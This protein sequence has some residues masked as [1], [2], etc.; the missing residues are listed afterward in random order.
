MLVTNAGIYVPGS[1]ARE[2]RL[3]GEPGE[4][5]SD[6]A[7]LFDVL[8]A[9]HGVDRY[10]T[11]ALG[12]VKLQEEVGEACRAFLRGNDADLAKELGDVVL[13]VQGVARHLGIDVMTAVRLN[14]ENSV[15]RIVDPSPFVAPS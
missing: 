9:Y 12:L 11:P 14:V 8:L 7:A 4:H 15:G 3:A 2:E 6:L 10:P 13:A 5:V 1:A